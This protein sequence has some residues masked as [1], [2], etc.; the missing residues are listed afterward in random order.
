MQLERRMEAVIKDVAPTQAS[1][2]SDYKSRPGALIW[3]FKKSRDNW[4]NKY[5]AAKAT[6]KGHQNRVADVIK[7]RAQWKLAAERARA[8]LAAREAENRHLRAQL[9]ALAD[10]KKTPRCPGH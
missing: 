1:T 10:E 4:K 9:A 3:F 2:N 5:K 6:I 7:S 8:Q